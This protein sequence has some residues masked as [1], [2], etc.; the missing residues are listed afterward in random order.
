MN[1]SER[2]II[3]VDIGGSHIAAG[4]LDWDKREVR[5]GSQ[6]RRSVDSHASADVII[7]SWANLLSDFIDE[8]NKDHVWV[9]IA[10]PGPFD[11]NEGISYINELN[12]YDALYGMNVKKE[13]AQALGISPDHILFKNDAE[14][15]LYGEVVHRGDL[16]EAKV[17]GITLGTGL[18]SAVYNHGVCRDV[19]RAITPMKHGIAEDYISSR[20]FKHRY[21]QLSG[22]QLESVEALAKGQDPLKAQIFSEFATHLAFFL[23]DFI[24]EESA[25][26]VIIGGNIARCLDL[27]IDE[28]RAKLK[29]KQVQLYQSILWEDA[30]LLGAGYLWENKLTKSI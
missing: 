9:G 24:E 15:F 6:C 18:G 12:K 21:S 2:K 16:D 3:V 5:S 22:E 10:M 7:S 28:L 23:N 20:W 29:N 27:F 1:T 4:E 17:V 13:L 19:F 11:Y 25:S 14:A 8:V 26:A 30:A